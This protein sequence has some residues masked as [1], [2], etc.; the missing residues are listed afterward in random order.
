MLYAAMEGNQQ[1]PAPTTST[2]SAAA[3]VA[4]ADSAEDNELQKEMTEWT[5]RL[6]ALKDKENFEDK[7]TNAEPVY[8]C[9]SFAV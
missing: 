3:S 4:D 2:A 8:A 5:Q 1:A 6:T 9:D 7:V